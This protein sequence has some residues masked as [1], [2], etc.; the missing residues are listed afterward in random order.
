MTTGPRNTDPSP[1]LLSDDALLDGMHVVYCDSYLSELEEKGG[2]LSEFSGKRCDLIIAPVTGEA[3]QKLLDIG[4]EWEAEIS[5]AWG[6]PVADVMMEYGRECRGATMEYWRELPGLFL[7]KLFAACIGHGVGLDD[8]GPDSPFDAVAERLNLGTGKRDAASPVYL[9]DSGVR[10]DIASDQ[11]EADL[12]NKVRKYR[13]GY[14][15]RR[16]PAA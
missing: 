3:R 14:S 8:D 11:V 2:S 13:K 10:F 12:D 5:K 1:S 9:D 6:K 16:R 4:R 15:K 7:W